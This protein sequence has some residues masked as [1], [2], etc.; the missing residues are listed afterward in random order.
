MK[1]CEIT[2]QEEQVS[3]LSRAERE[4]II[5][6]FVKFV[7]KKLHITIP[8]DI[9]FSYDKQEAQDEHHTGSYN[10]QAGKI[11]VYMNNRNLVDI[12]RTISHEL[13]HVK[14]AQD[15]R[16]PNKTLP[17]GKTEAEAASVAGWLIKLYGGKH[18]EIFE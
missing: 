4:E 1:I 16:L 15:G 14:Q 8:V 12:L 13:E 3:R 7:M 5:H 2:R 9:E 18:H 10:K 11:W 17:N 6:D